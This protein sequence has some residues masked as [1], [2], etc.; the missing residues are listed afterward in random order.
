LIGAL[1]LL[2]RQSDGMVSGL[3]DGTVSRLSRAR[4]SF[5]VLKKGRALFAADKKL[6]NAG[7]LAI[8]DQERKY[9]IGVGRGA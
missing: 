2:A 9:L 3:S 5:P 7:E 4:M 1:C 6:G 8:L